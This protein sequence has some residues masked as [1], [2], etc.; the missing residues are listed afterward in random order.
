MSDNGSNSDWIY[1]LLTLIAG[2]ASLFK[3]Q[4]TKKRQVRN[5][6]DTSKI[7][8][9][10]QETTE[11]D[12]EVAEATEWP[13]PRVQSNRFTVTDKQEKSNDLFK[14]EVSV[15]EEETESYAFDLRQAIISNEILNRKYD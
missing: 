4:K 3:A 14:E 12:Y 11:E 15:E 10:L 7:P 13:D 6:P 8:D 1:L 5:T 9:L 2:I